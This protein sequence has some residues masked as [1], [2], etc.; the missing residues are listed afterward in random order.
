LFG[1]RLITSSRKKPALQLARTSPSAGHDPSKNGKGEK[2]WSTCGSSDKQ[3][4]RHLTK[5]CYFVFSN[6]PGSSV[7]PSW[8]LLISDGSASFLIFI[9]GDLHQFHCL[10]AKIQMDDKNINH[11]T[12][13]TELV[14]HLTE[15]EIIVDSCCLSFRSKSLS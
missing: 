5:R 10:T 3:T 8:S 2:K 11:S 13:L 4:F 9:R 14:S 15:K 6:Q 7:C 12:S 1:H